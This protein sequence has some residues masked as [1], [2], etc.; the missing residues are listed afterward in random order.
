MKNYII[1]HRKLYILMKYIVKQLMTDFPDDVACL[2]WLV[3]YLY[4]ME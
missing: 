3:Q 4:L 1:L 2:E